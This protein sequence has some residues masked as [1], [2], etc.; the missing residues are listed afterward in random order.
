MPWSEHVY[1]V[2]IAFKM[3]EW[4]EQWIYIKFCVK[5]EHSSME[6]IQMIQKATAMGNW[7]LAVSS[8]KCAHWGIMSPV[9]FY[10]RIS[11]QSGDSVPLYPRFGTLQLLPF[12]KTKITFKRE[13]IS[14]QGWDSGKSNGATDGDWENYVRSQG[15]Y[16]EG[17]WGVIVLCTMSLA[18][19]IFFS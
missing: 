9:D 10:G 8:W 4:V 11:N 2:S 12:P 14:D 5:F 13:G 17:N 7:W 19:C 16:F 6:T 1:C 15:A 18:S 3:S